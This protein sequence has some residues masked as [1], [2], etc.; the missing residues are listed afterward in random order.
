M[1]I[2]QIYA[3]VFKYKL[4]SQTVDSMTRMWSAI[5]WQS[6][7]YQHRP[8]YLIVRP[9]PSFFSV[10]SKRGLL[11]D[12][13]PMFL[14]SSWTHIT[15]ALGYF[16]S[17]AFTRS[18]GNG[19]IWTPAVQYRLIIT[20]HERS[21]HS[22]ISATEGSSKRRPEISASRSLSCARAILHCWRPIYTASDVETPPLVHIARVLTRRQNIWCYTAQHTTQHRCGGSHGQISTIKATQD[23]YGA[24]QRGSGWWPDP[25]P[26]MRER[27][28]LTTFALL[29]SR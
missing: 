26:G 18:I 10:A 13:A 24:S 14:G 28:F 4:L 21:S 27:V 29:Y 6:S 11:Y 23:A 17:S 19:E 1:K 5:Y 2:Q 22:H 20:E 12:Q 8:T 15:V 7:T 16:F 9:E 3:A 25:R